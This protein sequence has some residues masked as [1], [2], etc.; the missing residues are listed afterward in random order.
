MCRKRYNFSLGLTGVLIA[1]FVLALVVPSYAET[2]VTSQVQLVKSTLNYDRLTKTSYFD[3]SVKNTGT[4]ALLA[5]IKVVVNA[6]TPVSV[7]VK[8]ADG[9]ISDGKPYYLYSPSSGFLA[10]GEVS[11]SKRWNFSNPTAAKFNYTTTAYGTVSEAAAL[12]GSNGGSIPVTDSSSALTGFKIEVPAGTFSSQATV[13]IGIESNPPSQPLPQGVVQDGP[14]IS[15]QSS[16]IF[17][18]PVKLYIPFTGD[19]LDG[20]ARL[21]Y[22]YNIST[23]VWELVV[24]LPTS[25]PSIFVASIKHFCTYVKGRATI[26]DTNK[27]TG[28]TMN[29]DTLQYTNTDPVSNGFPSCSLYETTHGT[30]TGIAYLS[31]SYFNSIMAQYKDNL[32]CHWNQ[33][34]A[35][36]AACEAHQQYYN[37]L[38]CNDWA[39]VGEA[40]GKL[41]WG[42]SLTFFD[43]DYSYL[44]DFLKQ[45]ASLNTV[46]P[47]DMRGTDSNG[48]PANHS[49]VA[50]GW[51]KTGL[52][53]GTIKVYDVNHNDQY[54]Y[55]YYGRPNIL[56]TMQYS[57]DG[58]IYNKFG[59]NTEY[60]ST[61]IAS[62]FASVKRTDSDL[63]GV[64]DPCDKCP[65]TVLGDPVDRDGCSDAQGGNFD[66]DGDG[67]RDL[68]D[69]CPNTPSGEAVNQDGCSFSQLAP[70]LIGPLSNSTGVDI[71]KLQFQWNP[72]Q[73]PALKA[74][75]YCVTIKEHSFPSDIPV[76]NGCDNGILSPQNTFPNSLGPDLSTILMPQTTYWWAV[77]AKDSDGLWSKASDWW[78][79]TTASANLNPPSLNDPQSIT[80][81]FRLTWSQVS[82]ATSYKLYWGN[83]NSVSEVNHAAIQETSNT[84]FDHT[85]LVAG[86]PYFYRVMA[87]NGANCSTL[88]KLVSATYAGASPLP[89]TPFCTALAVIQMMDRILAAS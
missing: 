45:Q 27:D 54:H 57:A 21:V 40:W 50:V 6:L 30:C 7:T 76:W 70:T 11:G 5:P 19:R 58:Y 66:A 82:G 43:F 60:L 74:V 8:N 46:T 65:N 12:I 47:I 25:D 87:C 69:K 39:C 9:V 34:D 68:Y 16:A 18:S 81:G 20:E 85:G 1:F 2:D 22:T 56:L 23:G 61:D 4:G 63:D 24:P 10:A 67:V 51:S 35:S 31:S 73:H 42:G 71:S 48:N 37:L 29:V 53:S 75:Q 55:V 64:G 52:F 77:W 79:F 13:S 49:V 28:F 62:I 83:D 33:S 41:Y 80:G 84:V 44:V 88:S 15:L 32:M 78:N 38:H 36:V 86:S 26:N 89:Y 59:I 3:V 72:I 14:F 17:Q